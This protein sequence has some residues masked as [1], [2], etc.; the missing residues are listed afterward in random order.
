M[1]GYEDFCLVDPFFYDAPALSNDEH[2]AFLADLEPPSGWRRQSSGH[3]MLMHPD[4]ATLPSQGWKVHVAATLASLD[5][6]LRTTW[7]FCVARRLPFKYLRNRNLY[8]TQNTKYADR[9]SSGKL[10]TLYPAHD[11]ELE[12]TLHEL[13]S[14]LDGH[15]SPYILSDLRWDRGPLYVRYG[16]F[17]DRTCRAE[18]GELVAAVEDPTGRL[19]PDVRHL[20][21]Q[22]PVWAPIPSCLA[23]TYERFQAPVDEP[24]PY[25]ITEALHYSNGGGVYLATDDRTGSAVVLKE[26]RP[27]A[28]IDGDGNDA[29]D[30]LDRE[31]RALEMLAGLE[32]V[33]RLIEQR[34]WWEHHFLVVERVEG[35]T[36]SECLA[37]RQPML[38]RDSTPAERA[39]YA[40]WAAHILDQVELGLAAMHDRSVIFGDLHPRNVIVR[41]DDSI[42][43]V[44]FELASHVDENWSPTLGDPGFAAPS[45]TTGFA[46]DTYA[47]GCVRVASFLPL[48]S[49]LRWEHGKLDDLLAAITRRFP[50][51]PDFVATVRR[52][53]GRVPAT[54]APP[55]ANGASSGRAALL[56]PT[57]E[58]DWLTLLASIGAA[59]GASATPERSDR[60]FPGDPAQF[61]D[62]G[63]GGLSFA[64]GAAGILWALHRVGAEVPI[65]HVDWI[66][67]NL[68][69]DTPSPPGFYNGTTGIAYALHVLGRRDAAAELIDHLLQSPLDDADVSLYSGAAGVGLAVLELG[70]ATDD[71][72]WLR[73]A[74]Q[75]AD[76]VLAALHH[77]SANPVETGL[78][79]GWSGPALF[80]LRLYEATADGALLAAAAAA[81]R[82]DLERCL[83]TDD[84]TLQVDQDWR[85][86]PYL[87]IGSAGIGAVADELSRH[88]RDEP[89]D[90]DIDGLR[91]ASC[92]E[93]LV[94]AGLFN[95]RAGL[96]LHLANRGE[97]KGPAMRTHL[98]N[99]AWHG[100]SF[101]GELAFVGD[102]L[103]RLSMDLATGSAGVLLALA[104]ALDD[105]NVSLPFLVRGRTRVR[106][107][108]HTRGGDTTWHQS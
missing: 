104:A 51:P 43:F 108:E 39:S 72:R 97:G 93:A 27:F 22:P 60:L 48:T 74:R 91:R 24:L 92:A 106:D 5:D 46:I 107:H 76:G 34:T 84:Q 40:E 16:G 19:V 58:P 30:R 83:W 6:V 15:D 77:G 105:P 96:M 13:G 49:L 78:M 37:D 65:E 26:A 89:L 85:L 14:I 36:L 28:G 82:R 9:R 44:D 1:A 10:L 71:Q 59:I 62:D 88:T 98:V 63:L 35:Q 68:R 90:R 70:Q 50:V 25:T 52:D 20:V 42:A 57:G 79:H 102:Q 8:I 64:Y 69:R 29:V 7:D 18:S 75:L 11:A 32:C 80:L 94:Q 99:L 3:W 12:R 86:L 31:R 21:F 33:P 101:G 38:R 54:D 100:V 4:G 95:G 2:G 56:P 45:G 55:P 47:L 87:S 73:S 66:V 17:R 103:L 67:A 23:A 61:A 81:L 53:L 41:P